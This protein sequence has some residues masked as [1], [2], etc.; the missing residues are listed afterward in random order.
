[1]REALEYWGKFPKITAWLFGTSPREEVQIPEEFLPD[2][3]RN[4]LPGMPP[5]IPAGQ[6]T[7]LAK[8]KEVIPGDD[9]QELNVG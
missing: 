2:H 7:S 1:M 4:Q 8:K 3:L 6:T 5:I 9:Q